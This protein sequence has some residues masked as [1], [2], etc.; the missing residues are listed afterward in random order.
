MVEIDLMVWVKEDPELGGYSRGHVPGSR[1]V[2]LP[3]VPR[4]GDLVSI[5]KFDEG[6][7]VERVV[8]MVDEP[9]AIVVI[10]D[11][12]TR[13]EMGEVINHW[14]EHGFTFDDCADKYLNNET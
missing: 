7:V 3:A 12:G 11:S 13:S 14:I 8:L 1:R 2:S 5:G 6:T 9:V 10:T 4:V